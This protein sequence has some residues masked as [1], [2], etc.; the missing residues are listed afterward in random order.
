MDGDVVL[1]LAGKIGWE[2]KSFFEWI[3]PY[4]EK[5]KII[6]TGYVTQLQLRALLQSCMFFAFPS[7]YEGFGIPVLEAMASGA[8]VLTSDNS[9]LRELFNGYALLVDP[10]SVESIKVGMEKFLDE[11]VR[12]FYIAKGK[13]LVKN[14]SWEKCS[15]EHERVFSNII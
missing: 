9:S 7:L 12:Q 13:E 8:P 3:Q 2:D 1:V 14:F 6:V 11:N 10:L 15:G 5:H 4:I